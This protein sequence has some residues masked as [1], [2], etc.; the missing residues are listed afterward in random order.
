[1]FGSHLSVAGGLVN[2]LEEAERLG[3]DCVQIFTKNQR[4]WRVPPLKEAERDA[5]LAKL[6]AM[7]WAKRR[8]PA[9]VV[10]H[11]SYLVN[12]ASPDPEARAKSIA[13][14]RAEL[15]RCEALA[16][17][18]CVIHPGAHLG[19]PAA[20]TGMPLDLEAAPTEDE[21]AGLDGIVASLDA[22][23]RD[24]PGLAVV[25]CLESTVGTGT[26]L[27]YALHHLARL[28]DG[29]AEPERIAFCLDTCHLLA[30]G[31]DL[32]TERG[33]K[34]V[35]AR[36]GRELGW[37]L[38]RVI[39]VNDSEGGVGS[40]KDRHAH[41]GHGLCGTPCFRTLV[42]HARLRNVPKILE[43]AKE[44]DEKGVPWDVRNVRRLKGLIRRPASGR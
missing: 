1:M 28:R 8:G 36:A 34:A 43:T 23:H 9:R 22:I 29:V 38:I 2:A 10:S 4:Q 35:F 33:A 25:T 20:P 19:T 40:R 24:L 15:E 13:L 27:G 37:P 16:I 14:H 39:H 31:Y 18:C 11:G 32:T 42:N 7:G 44:D 41:I 21:Q 12:L 6:A 3:L 26:N 17:P 30:A 5:W